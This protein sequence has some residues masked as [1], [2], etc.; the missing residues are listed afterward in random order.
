MTRRE[1][2]IMHDI[3]RTRLTLRRLEHELIVL[4]G[5]HTTLL[6]LPGTLDLTLTPTRH[7]GPTAAVTFPSVLTGPAYELLRAQHGRTDTDLAGLLISAALDGL[8]PDQHSAFS[9]QLRA[10]TQIRHKNMRPKVLTAAHHARLGTLPGPH[11]RGRVLGLLIHFALFG[12]LGDP[13]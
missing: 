13:T 10:P 6:R 7:I 5:Q 3:E 4:R 11:P 2:D 8:T 1:V 9:A 12:T